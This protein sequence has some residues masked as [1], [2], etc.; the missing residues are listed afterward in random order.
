MEI[1]QFFSYNE[2]YVE[3]MKKF[4]AKINTSN[5]FVKVV[6]TK[7]KFFKYEIRKFTIDYSKNAAKRKKQ[8]MIKNNLTSE[9]NRKLYSHYKNDLGTIY[10]HVTDVIKVK[11]E[12]EWYEYGEKP[13]K[14]FLTLS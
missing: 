3:N 6:Q 2:V 4:I 14:L 8:Q 7:W 10:D 13:I 11:S 9:E 1:Y 12:Y 5:K